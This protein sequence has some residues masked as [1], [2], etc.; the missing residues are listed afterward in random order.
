MSNIKK[1]DLLEVLAKAARRACPV[2]PTQNLKEYGTGKLV[3]RAEGVAHLLIDLVIAE[4]IVEDEYTTLQCLL[5]NRDK[6][7]VLAE[8]AAKAELEA[9]MAALG[10]DPETQP[11]D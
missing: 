1:K 7:E 10:E 6:E 9:E 4:I 11:Q 5:S 2:L 3:G 8:Q